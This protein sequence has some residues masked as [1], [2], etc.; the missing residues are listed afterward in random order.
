MK[1]KI[2]NYQVFLQFKQL[3]GEREFQIIQPRNSE[4]GE[5]QL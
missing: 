1:R 4:V 5:S 2:L 3:K